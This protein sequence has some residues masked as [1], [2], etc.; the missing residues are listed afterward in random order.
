MSEQQQESAELLGTHLIERRKTP[1]VLQS[2]A[3]E[4]GLASLCMAMAT[5]GRNIDLIVLRERYPASMRGVS[6]ARLGEIA[7]KEGF[8]LTAYTAE[9]HQMAELKLPGILHWK[10]NHFVVLTEYRPGKSATIHDPAVGVRK[11]N[12]E[13]FVEGFSG[14]CCEL[15]P[16]A[17]MKQEVQKERLSIF[18]LLKKTNG[19]GG[20]LVKM[21]VMALV[22][23]ALL[24]VS[25]LF[26]QTV[27]DEVI[28]VRDDRL[29]WALAAGF[30]GL[31]LI[32]SVFKLVHGWLGM[33][34]TGMLAL[35]MKQLTFH[36]L[37]RLP[38]AWFEKR[39]VGTVT[40]RFHSLN[41]IRTT[42]SDNVLLALVDSIVAVLMVVVLLVYEWK[43]A[44]LTLAVSAVSFG[45]TLLLYRRY[46]LA[47]SEGVLA[48]AEENRVL[49]ESVT[50]MPAV[51]M[52]GQEMRQLRNYRRTVVTSTNRMLDMLRVKTWHESAQTL[53][54]AVGDVAIVTAAAYFVLS[55]SLSLG[56]MFGFY[57]YKGI[58]SE[59]LNS[60]SNS[61]FS[62]RLLSIYTANV[63]DVLLSP[64]EEDNDRPLKVGP[65][66]SLH[67]DKV[68][69]T[70]DEADKPTLTDFSL[71]VAPGE[72]VG[73]TGPSGGGKST[74][75]KLLTGSLQP[76]AGSI[77]LDQEE[78]VGVPPKRVREHLGVVLQSDHLL[79]GTL[80]DNITMFELNPDMDKVVQAV[81]D[82]ALDEDIA[83]I[84]TGLNTFILG[85]APTLS[86]GQKQRLLLARAFYKNASVLVLDE[87]T[88]ALDVER[89]IH[90]C[91]SIRR[92]GLTTLM[93]AHRHETLSRCD[94]VVRVGG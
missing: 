63:A 18:T 32:K 61:Y 80:L 31:A 16:L 78:L 14:A 54:T 69:F 19:Y 46:A 41:S 45:A 9:A 74:L 94:R 76:S 79:T 59:K 57:A 75:I 8:L 10:G 93:V 26:L 43:L 77:R 64:T 38:L 90:V 89:E 50:A 55:G 81:S 71:T 5:F 42:L 84:P 24:L 48:D 58:L 7:E 23:E 91:E 73:V 22:L 51:K 67:F 68:S 20:M 13:Q 29:L 37:L 86:G 21:G 25:P 35:V 56:V 70:Y 88:S 83:A 92:K 47:A 85:H 33:A 65:R 11:L 49:V 72:I 62:F 44:L 60:L 17:T 39:G 66:P 6:I 15:E 87:A 27:V 34:L 30:A 12:W 28:P 52:F 40:A 4:C 53:L 82:A 36:H 3:M 1:V 2:E